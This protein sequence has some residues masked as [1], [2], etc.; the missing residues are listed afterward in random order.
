[1]APGG[2]R[3]GAI[4]PRW[5]PE[6]N[7]MAHFQDAPVHVWNI[8][9]VQA[10]LYIN[11]NGIMGSSAWHLA[12]GVRYCWATRQPPH[13][14]YDADTWRHMMA[15]IITRAAAQVS[16]PE[17]AAPHLPSLLRGCWQQTAPGHHGSGWTS[18]HS[19]CRRCG[20]CKVQYSQGKMARPAA[21]C[22]GTAQE[23]LLITTQT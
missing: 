23:I 12:R 22:Q 9:A 19:Q 3:S 6:H 20:S 7:K 21:D 16:T 17:A 18:P 10:R 13:Q 1:V 2:G 14:V 4:A 8:I 15:A 5:R 11:E